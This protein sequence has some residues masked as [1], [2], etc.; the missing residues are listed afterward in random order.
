[1]CTPGVSRIKIG[2]T[3]SIPVEDSVSSSPD[4]ST[5]SSSDSS[6]LTEK[7]MKL[8]LT[9]GNFHGKCTD[10]DVYH[11]LFYEL[12]ADLCEIFL[13]ELQMKI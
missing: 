8:S 13:T 2:I 4:V 9:K 7:S 11:I 10:F 12:P 3:S 5:S 1:M 6:L